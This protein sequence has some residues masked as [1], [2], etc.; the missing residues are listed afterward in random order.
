MLELSEKHFRQYYGNSKLE[1][2]NLKNLTSNDDFIPNLFKNSLNELKNAKNAKPPRP[3][4][5]SIDLRKAQ[6]VYQQFKKS[7][8]D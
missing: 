5:K 7:K 8:P 6:R 2:Q 1:I 4:A 3:L